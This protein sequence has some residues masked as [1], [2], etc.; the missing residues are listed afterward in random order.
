M[1]KYAIL[2]FTAKG[3]SYG[4]APDGA[5]PARLNQGKFNSSHRK[6]DKTVEDLIRNE[7]GSIKQFI[8]QVEALNYCIELGWTLEQTIFDSHDG[9]GSRDPL[10]NFIF[11]LSRQES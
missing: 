2:T 3:M 4:T 6:S 7:D 9:Y 8:S 11:L 1:K 5:G 10:S